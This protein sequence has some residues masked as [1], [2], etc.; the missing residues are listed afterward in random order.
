MGKPESGENVRL[1]WNVGGGGIT[2]GAVAFSEVAVAVAV[3][4]AVCLSGI[5][6][7]KP[8]AATT[9]A[10]VA[11][12]APA[13]ALWPVLTPALRAAATLALDVVVGI[14]LGI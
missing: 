1:R 2:T 11:I 13:L 10:D 7:G 3:A 14:K 6:V 5:A 8:A 4:V 9:S 12:P